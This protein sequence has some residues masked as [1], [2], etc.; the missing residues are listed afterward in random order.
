ML[1][2][3]VKCVERSIWLRYSGNTVILM[4]F[5]YLFCSW[6][7]LLCLVSPSCT[8]PDVFNVL[9][10]NYFLIYFVCFS[11]FL[12]PLKLSATPSLLP[13]WSCYCSP[14]FP[15]AF[16]ACL[17]TCLSGEFTVL[18]HGR[19]GVCSFILFHRLG[20]SFCASVKRMQIIIWRIILD[21]SAHKDT[22]AIKLEE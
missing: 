2:S 5:S 8:F 16:A 14:V 11:H 22:F 10:F 3:V 7:E 9:C 1:K 19:F 13:S 6:H 17:H 15:P 12:L 4:R 21:H 20:K 18:V